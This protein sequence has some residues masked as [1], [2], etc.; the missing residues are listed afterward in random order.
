MR[1]TT[2]AAFFAV[3]VA[4]ALLLAIGVRALQTTQQELAHTSTHQQ[5]VFQSLFRM[6][7]AARE[8]VVILHS[9][10]SMRDPFAIEEALQQFYAQGT[11]FAIA[12][13]ELMQLHADPRLAEMLALQRSLALD[14]VRKQDHFIDLIRAARYAEAERLLLGQIQPEQDRMLA[15][16][17]AILE[18]QLSQT[19]AE[20]E[21]S[22]GQTRRALGLMWAFGL[23]ALV[24]VVVIGL[25]TARYLLRLTRHM[26]GQADEL[27]VSLNE[28]A[29]Q[30]R[31]LDEHNIVSI[32]DASGNITYANDLFCAVSQYSRDELIGKNH[33]LLKSGEHDTAFFDAMWQ[34]ISSG[35]VWQGEI[36]NRRK[37]GAHYW[38]A[39]TIVPFLDM[40]GLPYKYVSIRTDITGIKEAEGVMRRSKAELETM[41]E[42]R[43]AALAR[44]NEVLAR[45]IDERRKLQVELEGLATTDSL[46]GAS[47]RRH[48]N[49]ALQTEMRRAQRYH[50]PL[51]LIL[52]DI[53]YFKRVNDMHG[54]QV[55]DAVLR[56]F[57]RLVR[58]HVRAQDFLARWGG[59]EFVLL[60]PQCD[61]DC[62]AA[63]AEKLRRMIDALDFEV[64]GHV[65]CSFGVAEWR[66]GE[67]HAQWLARADQALYRAKGEGRNRVIALLKEEVDAK[68]VE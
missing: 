32:T 45:E 35:Q 20:I 2:F 25:F 53:D 57:T 26:Q 27:R 43:T 16:L 41:V 9:M 3:A 4:T 13:A 61:L 8:R 30:T 11:E 21:A 66:S 42:D 46:T 50:A 40:N 28:L 14:I 47:N 31:A 56:E 54:H 67:P 48:F 44:A 51:S 29:Y 5:V 58:D 1:L 59:E 17:S 55:G 65:T 39:T 34:T 18:Y 23:A 64:A 62:A 37:D 49:E 36:C 68:P 22:Q 60:T 15:Q 6:I 33:R 24:L 7:A 12:R 10:H 63:L 52:M 38:V 19:N